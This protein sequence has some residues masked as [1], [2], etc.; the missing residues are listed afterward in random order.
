MHWQRWLT[1]GIVAAAV[2]FSAYL[3]APA[4]MG[5]TPAPPTVGFKPGIRRPILA[6]RP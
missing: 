2:A 5:S 4:L 6:C 1:W 3:V